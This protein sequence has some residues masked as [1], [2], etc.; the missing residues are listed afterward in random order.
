MGHAVTPAHTVLSSPVPLFPIIL[1][2]GITAEV[3]TL[4][5]DLFFALPNISTLNTPDGGHIRILYG[6]VTLFSS[7]VGFDL[8]TTFRRAV[9]ENRNRNHWGEQGGT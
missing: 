8:I 4:S 7:Q 3:D 2:G 5:H 1:H 6:N 9:V